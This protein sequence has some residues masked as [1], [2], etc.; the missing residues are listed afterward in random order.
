VRRTRTSAE[1]AGVTATARLPAH[2]AQPIPAAQLVAPISHHGRYC[3][4]LHKSVRFLS[5]HIESGRHLG[6]ERNIMSGPVVH[7]AENSPEQVAYKLLEMIA[8]VERKSLYIPTELDGGHSVAE[9]E[10]I[11]QTYEEC[12]G[13]VRRA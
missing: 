9:R 10:W 3:V 13:C 8:K 6:T 11:L 2:F 12:L 5:T 7:I 4:P 1:I